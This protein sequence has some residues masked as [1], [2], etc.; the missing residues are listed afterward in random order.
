MR[1]IQWERHPERGAWGIIGLLLVVVI[2]MIVMLT[3][4]FSR[5]PVTEVTTAQTQIDRSQ[6]VACSANRNTIITSLTA[7]RI[8][9][10]SVPLDSPEARQS[11]NLPQCPE[12][13]FYMI[14]PDGT[15]YCS[16]HSP[17]PAEQMQRMI[18]LTQAQLTPTPVGTPNLLGN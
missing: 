11:L 1:P 18:Q 6:A 9:N 5:D 14:G 15:I 8:N 2:I 17:P 3:G 13:G 10:S 4:P 7:F 12:G 16:V